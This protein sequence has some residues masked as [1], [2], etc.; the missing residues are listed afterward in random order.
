M[1]RRVLSLKPRHAGAL[2]ELGERLPGEG[3]RGVLKKMLG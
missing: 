1:F 3:A 2:A